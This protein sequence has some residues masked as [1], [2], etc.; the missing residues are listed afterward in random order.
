MALENR[1]K[2]GVDEQGSGGLW[3]LSYEMVVYYTDVII[4]DLNDEEYEQYR[5][6]A[7]TLYDMLVIKHISG[8]NKGDTKMENNFKYYVEISIKDCE[9]MEDYNYILQ[10]DWFDTEKEALAWAEKISHV[11]SVVEVSLM[12]ANWDFEYDVIIDI[13]FVRNIK[14]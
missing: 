10:S 7:N 4:H 8:A 6:L 12:R 3:D 2:W 14:I 11:D 13:E 5:W 9:C 1:K